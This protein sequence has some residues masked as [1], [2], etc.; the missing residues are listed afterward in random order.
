MEGDPAEALGSKNFGRFSKWLEGLCVDLLKFTVNP[1][2]S[3]VF[4]EIQIER[5]GTIPPGR[6]T[7]T[8]TQDKEFIIKKP[9]NKAPMESKPAPRPRAKKYAVKN[10]DRVA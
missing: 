10:R 6:K 2:E 9:K 3:M 4:E 8:L 1:R 7:V 5:Q